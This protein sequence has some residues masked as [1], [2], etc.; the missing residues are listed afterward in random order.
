MES[1]DGSAQALTPVPSRATSPLRLIGYACILVAAAF[2]QRGDDLVADT[3]FDLVTNPLGFL[4]RGLRLWDPIAAFGQIQNQ[5]YG[6]LWPMGPFFAVGHLL[7]L[8]AW[9]IQRAWWALLLC[10]AFFGMLLL[11]R[12]LGLGGPVSQVV[13]AF[14]YALTPRLTSLLGSTSVEVWPMAVAPWVL[15]ALIWG[16]SGGSTRRSTA[17]AA[18][19]VACAGG[20]NAIAVAAVLPLGVLWLLTRESGP[21]KWQLLGWWTALTMA[22]TA[23][24]WGPLL[25]M[26]RYSAPFLDYIENAKITSI[27]TDVTRT[28]V[29]VSDWVAYF[30][31]NDFPAGSLLVSTPFLVID[32][33]AIAAVGLLGIALS[34]NPHR[35]FL[36]L[37]LLT[38]LCLVGFG[39]AGDWAGVA[40][41]SRNALLDGVLSPLRNLHKFDVVLRIPLILGLAHALHVVPARLLEA[42]A[43]AARRVLS[44]AAVLV[45][46]AMVLP[47]FNGAISPGPGVPNVPGYWKSAARYLHEHDD[48]TVSLE[49]PASAFG[50]YIWGNVHDDVMQGLA[51]SPWAVRNAIPLAQPG[52]VAMLDAITRVV[53]SGRPDPNLAAFLADNGVGRLIVRNDLDRLVTGAPD[54]AYIRSMLDRTPGLAYETG[55]GP[56]TGEPAYHYVETD[57]EPIRV[58]TNDGLSSRGQM[59]EVYQVDKAASATLTST[60][61]EIVGDPAARLSADVAAVT[62]PGVLATTGT[63]RRVTGQVLTDG[64]KRR[65][66]NF[67]SVRWNQTSTMAAERPYLLS[68]KEKFHRI[69]PRD[70]NWQTTE[71]WL[72][73]IEGVF[74]S[75]SQAEASALPPLDVGSHP[76]AAV[77]R[78][79]QTAW[80]SARDRSGNGQW[81]QVQFS[82]PKALTRVTLTMAPTSVRVRN[83]EF[84]AGSQAVTRPAPAPGATQ[85]YDLPFAPAKTLRVTAEGVVP[86]VGSVSIAEIDVA[87]VQS[88]RTLRLPRPVNTLPIDEIALQRDRERS[89]CTVIDDH[90]VCQDLLGG[91]GEDGDRLDRRFYVPSSDVYVGSARASL[92]STPAAWRALLT[93]SHTTVRA[94]GGAGAAFAVQPGAMIDGDLGTTWT[95]GNKSPVIRLRFDHP[96]QIDSLELRVN[97]N[98]AASLPNEFRVVADR[99]RSREVTLDAEGRVELPGWR[100][101]RLRIEVTG[102]QRSVYIRDFA[103]RNNPP[104]I[105]EIKINGQSLTPQAPLQFTCGQGPVLNLAGRVVP[106]SLRADRGALLRGESVPLTLCADAQISISG[107]A[108]VVAEPAEALRVDSVTLVRQNAALSATRHLSVRRTSRGAPASVQIPQERGGATSMRLLALP[109]NFNDGWVATLDGDRLE[110][111]QVDG[112]KQGW[113]LPK[114]SSGLVRFT[115]AP[116]NSLTWRLGLGAVGVVLVLALALIRDSRSHSTLNTAKRPNGWWH[117]LLLVGV[118]A[119][120]TGWLGVVIVAVALLAL[121]RLPRPDGWGSWAALSLLIAAL[122]LAWAPVRDSDAAVLWS[123]GFGMTAIALVGASMLRDCY[124]GVPISVRRMQ[125]PGSAGES[126]GS[127]AVSES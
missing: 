91:A 27:P 71:L 38:G 24:W 69:S 84:R 49:I 17:L 120:L 50:V 33:A 9:A 7:A 57:D 72:G 76:G 114:G 13:A 99:G 25:L 105:S 53:E 54:P 3:K 46:A 77:D 14:A 74:A 31:G 35:R 30:A 92:R 83:L 113:W 44:V 100:T 26:G 95:A 5:A 1:G 108:D 109:Q 8:P 70:E 89:G 123:Q 43:T 58:V 117:G 56:M 94:S 39:Y 12:R 32:A 19:A 67:A 37:G 47:W 68:G 102:V 90:V 55:F 75:T 106:T 79:P 126:G 65:E 59:I 2:S 6:Y 97:P 98:A 36:T 107:L 60:P 93:D 119:L 11:I 61:K 4:A 45:L 104:G 21:R 64:L 87:G 81:W 101:K 80:S 73:D 82:A 115:Y 122:A 78:N 52:N 48:G 118:G 51:E 20:V 103:I 34:D 10:A 88:R 23:W 28:L 110:P 40:A 16:T 62:G 85:T 42:G 96:R 15:V 124:W 121:R 86:K 116:S 18:L 22:A 29:G 63:Q 66:V 127:E 111:I 112:W 41:Q 125:K